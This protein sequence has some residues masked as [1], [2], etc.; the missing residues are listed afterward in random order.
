M[1][2]QRYFNKEKENELR[3]LPRWAKAFFAARTARRAIELIDGKKVVPSFIEVIKTLD[4]V[5]KAIEDGRKVSLG[6]GQSRPTD[7]SP[8]RDYAD[9][10]RDQFRRGLS[11]DYY[12]ALAVDDAYGLVT[13]IATEGRGREGAE[14]YQFRKISFAI[15][16][17]IQASRGV[18][19]ESDLLE[20]LYK[21]FD[22]LKEAVNSS[23]ITG[24]GQP[25]PRN[26]LALHC[27]I[28]DAEQ[29]VEVSSGINSRL[30][31]IL[32][33][34]P[35]KLYELDPSVFEELI[36]HI[37]YDF[38]FKVE[39]TARTRDGG[40]DIIAIC[41]SPTK[42]K[43]LIECKRYSERNKV[44][45]DIVQRL[46]GVVAGDGSTLGI[47]ATTSTFTKDATNFLNQPYVEYRLNGRDFN[48]IQDWL[49]MYERNQRIKQMIGSDFDVTESG[50]VLPRYSQ[51]NFA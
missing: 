28:D 29:L 4:E 31:S 9:Q 51:Q 12:A 42:K 1:E 7:I 38:G 17:A 32:N 27:C 48:G 5:E 40:K 21:D 8:A 44:G 45:I 22:L 34:N 13:N 33:Q 26:I 2:E 24:D 18:K 14:E 50:L 49:M 37:F 41:D 10:N 47:V 39:L 3:A 36:A 15:G 23:N 6:T 16:C 19:L 43:Y 11:P 25:V 46:H 20:C 30:I 35:K